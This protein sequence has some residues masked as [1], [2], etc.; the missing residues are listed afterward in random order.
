MENNFKSGFVTICGKPNV[1]K[2][3]ILNAIL[4]TKVSIVSDKPQTTRNKIAGIYH[5]SNGQIVFLDTPGIHRPLH[6]LNEYMVEVALRTLREADVI[7]FTVD[8]KEGLT[9]E[10]ELVIENLKRFEDEKPIVLTLNKIDIT[11][12]EQADSLRER[13]ENSLKIKATVKTSALTGE[14]LDKLIETIIS[15]LPIGYPYYPEDM[16]TDQPEYFFISE[17]IREKIFN[18]TRQEVPYSTAITVEKIEVKENTVVI[19]ATIFV[20]KETQKGILIGKDGNMIKK[21]G[22]FAR[23]DIEAYYGKKCYLNLWVKV[24]EKWRY[25][26]GSLN[27]LGYRTV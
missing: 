20:E 25:K 7:V 14:G 2:S 16:I 17:I 1:G 11:T 3:S 8:A 27:E 24:K 5:F 10:D 6:L 15:Y 23:K 19:D 12:E 9:E 4:K 21:I 13:I 26:K 22:K 18:L